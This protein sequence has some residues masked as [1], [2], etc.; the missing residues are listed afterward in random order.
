MRAVP[1]FENR[2]YIYV[3][4]NTRD[5]PDSR[6][7]HIKRNSN[8][9][10]ACR[11]GMIS[12]SA[13]DM[14]ALNGGRGRAWDSDTLRKKKSRGWIDVVGMTLVCEGSSQ[15]GGETVRRKGRGEFRR[16][17]DRS[18]RRRSL[19]WLPAPTHGG[20]DIVVVVAAATATATVV[21]VVEREVGVGGKWGQINADM[22]GKLHRDRSQDPRGKRGLCFSLCH[23]LVPRCSY[24]LSLSLC[25]PLSALSFISLLSASPLAINSLFLFLF[26]SHIFLSFSLSLYHSLTLSWNITPWRAHRLLILLMIL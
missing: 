17:G 7:G 4:T 25:V 26:F 22:C 19:G 24:S 23:S 2:I 1:H 15:R 21:V 9:I 16:L 12:G 13:R 8:H 10:D 5:C 20:G 3:S 18:Y 14:R 11:K 6:I